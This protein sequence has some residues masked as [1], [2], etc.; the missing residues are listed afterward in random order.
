[1]D[2]EPFRQ[3]LFWTLGTAVLPVLFVG[4]VWVI[5]R[6]VLNTNGSF[7]EVFGTGELLPLA[8]L[9]FL[10]V[11]ADIRLEGEDRPMGAAMAFQEVV[12]L[13]AAI[14]AIFLYGAI[15]THAVELVKTSSTKESQEA[16]HTFAVTSWAYIG[17]ALLHTVPV[18]AILIFGRQT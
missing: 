5:G 9:L 14:G 1:M 8:A 13:L 2:V 6:L 15:K 3:F 11:G 16:L 17:Y 4:M 7:S 12:F 18:K 10:S